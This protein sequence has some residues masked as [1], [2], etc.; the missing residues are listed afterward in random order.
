VTAL[1]LPPELLEELMRYSAPLSRHIIDT[2][3]Q[4]LDR[5]NQTMQQQPA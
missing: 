5:M 3:C 2:L 4:R 1:V